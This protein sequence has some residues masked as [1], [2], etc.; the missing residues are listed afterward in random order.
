MDCGILYGEDL[1][2]G[3]R[4]SKKWLDGHLWEKENWNSVFKRNSF[5][6]LRGQ[7]QLKPKQT[8]ALQSSRKSNENVKCYGI[9]KGS[10]FSINLK[11]F[12]DKLIARREENQLE[13]DIWTYQ[14]DPR[15]KDSK[16]FH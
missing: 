16:S 13:L 1:G 11:V 4:K 15:G 3:S 10:R 12:F 8:T 7:T 9:S 5:A 14:R 6:Y 2:N